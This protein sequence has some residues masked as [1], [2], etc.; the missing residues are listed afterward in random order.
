MSQRSY[1]LLISRDACRASKLFLRGSIGVLG[2]IGVPQ[3]F[4]SP[5]VQGVLGSYQ[6][7]RCLVIFSIVG[8][9]GCLG[10]KILVVAEC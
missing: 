8:V 10:I 5:S 3:A 2:H 1:S 6:G 4:H 7:L 9:S